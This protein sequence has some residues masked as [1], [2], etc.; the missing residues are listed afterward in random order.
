[1]RVA[2]LQFCSDDRVDRNL[3]ILT[4]LLQCAAAE[5][6]RLVALP[7]NFSF[8]HPDM[9]LKQQFAREQAPT[10]LRFLASAARDY[11]M[12][13]IGGSLLL[14]GEQLLRNC[15]PVYDAQGQELARYDKIHLF[16]VDLPDGQYQESAQ[17]EPGERPCWVDLPGWRLGISICYDLRFPEL[18]RHYA[19]QGCNLL[20]IPSAFTVPTGSAHWEVLLRARAIENQAFVLAPAQFGQHPGER[21]TYGHSMIVDPWGVVLARAENLSHGQG[22]LIFADLDRGSLEKVRQKIPALQ[23]R[24]QLKI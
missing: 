8:M 21:L 17:I 1:M 22:E 9:A 2:C 6:C 7:E 20:S 18:Y 14:P 4:D 24:R 13:I 3:A 12:M 11:R 15:C 16:N 10:V 23:H 5:G 19:S